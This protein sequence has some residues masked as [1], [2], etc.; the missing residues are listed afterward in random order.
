MPF[1]YSE[2]ALKWKDFSTSLRHEEEVWC[3]LSFFDP[4]GTFLGRQ[5]CAE[6]I[7]IYHGATCGA[8]FLPLGYGLC[9]HHALFC[10]TGKKRP[11]G[12]SGALENT[13]AFVFSGHRL[14]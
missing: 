9:G 10:L 14:F 1:H 13:A 11:A 12:D 3:I 5:F 8:G 4:G 7:Y 6:Q 2:D